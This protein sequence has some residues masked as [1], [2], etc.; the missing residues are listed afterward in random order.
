MNKCN[1]TAR[2]VRDDEIY[3]AVH[4]GFFFVD[5]AVDDDAVV[6]VGAV[7]AITNTCLIMGMSYLQFDNLV[8]TIGLLKLRTLC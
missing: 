1:G 8:V 3:Q 5:V 6:V 2:L 4:A 7:A